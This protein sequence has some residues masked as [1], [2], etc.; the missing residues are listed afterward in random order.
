IAELKPTADQITKLNATVVSGTPDATGTVS[1]TQGSGGLKLAFDAG[2]L[3][4]TI[5]LLPGDVTG[6]KAASGGAQPTT[7]ATTD[8]NAASGNATGATQVVMKDFEFAPKVI[9]I[10]AGTSVVFVNQGAKKHTATADDN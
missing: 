3:M 2:F 8:T 4:A 6:G 1:P 9:T 10:T 5:P 7:A